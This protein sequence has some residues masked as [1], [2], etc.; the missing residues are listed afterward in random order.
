MSTDSLAIGVNEAATA[1]APQESDCLELNRIN[2]S[3]RDH[4]GK[5]SGS[6]R[7]TG[8]PPHKEQEG[9][10]ISSCKTQPTGGGT[11]TSKSAHSNHIAHKRF[12]DLFIKGGGEEV[13]SGKVPVMCS[14]DKKHTPDYKD[15][16]KRKSGHAEARILDEL[17]DQKGMKMVFKIDWRP[18]SGGRSNLPCDACHRL[19]CIAM[20][21]CEH[22][23]WLCNRKNPQ[24]LTDDDCKADDEG[25]VTQEA[26]RSLRRKMRRKGLKKKS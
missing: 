14:K 5:N 3:L 23:I 9:T 18:R 25:N 21:E 1:E 10:T 4:V 26:R 20:K 7:L 12:S 2:E 11:A 24:K 8:M 19:M 17:G 16:Y 6:R 15:N 13:R 22:E